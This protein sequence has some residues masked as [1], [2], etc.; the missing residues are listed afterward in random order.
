MIN[1]NLYFS[2]EK[3]T[4]NESHQNQVFLFNNKT[5]TDKTIEAAQNYIFMKFKVLLLLNLSK[6]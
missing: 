5:R 3:Q 4:G 6:F 1:Q 2:G